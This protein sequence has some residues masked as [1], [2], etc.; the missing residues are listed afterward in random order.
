MLLVKLVIVRPQ[1]GVLLK[2]CLVFLSQKVSP[3]LQFHHLVGPFT[4]FSAHIL[5]VKFLLHHTGGFSLASLELFSES[6]VLVH[7][8]FAVV[9]LALESE[10]TLS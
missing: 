3:V 1:N 8:L 2:E 6:V 4:F 9:H 7:Q 5:V 10:F